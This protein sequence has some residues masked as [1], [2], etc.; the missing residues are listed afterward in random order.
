[1]VRKDQRLIFEKGLREAREPDIFGEEH[2]RWRNSPCKGPEQYGNGSQVRWQE[3]GQ[4]KA[5]IEQSQKFP[6]HTEARVESQE[7]RR[8]LCWELSPG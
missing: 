1:M 7:A 4:V 8:K 2:S 3:M 5:L 6:Q